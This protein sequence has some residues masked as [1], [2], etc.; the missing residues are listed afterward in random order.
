MVHIS[1]AS[2]GKGCGRRQRQAAVAAACA[3]A[4]TLLAACGAAGGAASAKPLSPRQVITLASDTADR[5]TSVTGNYTVQ[6]GTGPAEIT[7]GTVSVR[8]KPTFLIGE[9]LSVSADGQKLAMSEI[10][11]AQAIYLKEAALSGETGKPWVKISLSSLSGGLGSLVSQLLQTAQNSNPLG[12]TQ[13]LA[14]AK[15]VRAHGTQVVDG[16]QT[17]RYTGSVTP[18]AALKTLSP[19]LRASLAPMLNLISGD[20]AFT[21]W[22]D[23][24][25]HVRKLI[26][27]ETVSGQ[28]VTVTMNIT[29]INQPVHV[30]L[31]PASQVASMPKSALAGL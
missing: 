1:S 11:S 25:H 27:T 4:A 26:E 29:S 15:D 9:N 21:V 2:P 22:I 8:L 30:T 31:P 17:T 18:A 13:V 5:A 7:T 20:I 19:K 16:V 24:Q 14:S 28:P 3:A 23:G 12:Q 10:I 6:A